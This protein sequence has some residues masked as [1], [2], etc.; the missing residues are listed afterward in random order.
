MSPRPSQKFQFFVFLL[1][2]PARGLLNVTATDNTSLPAMGPV[3]FVN[4]L[5][6][7]VPPPRQA[8]QNLEH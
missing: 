5:N 1:M 2:Q 3:E 8:A 7:Q 6:Y 4:H